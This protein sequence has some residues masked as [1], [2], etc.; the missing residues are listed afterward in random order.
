VGIACDIAENLLRSIEWSFGVDDPFGAPQRR[1][2][3]SDVNR[4]AKRTPELEGS[5]LASTI[6]GGQVG[7]LVVETIAK[8]RRA[9]FV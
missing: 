3:A 9:F 2:V 4:R 7:M 6:R 5:T 1:E 8:I